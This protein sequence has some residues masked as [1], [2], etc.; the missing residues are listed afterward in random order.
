MYGRGDGVK[1]DHGK[2]R[3]WFA[4]G[5]AAGS[6]LAMFNLG[7]CYYNGWGVAADQ[8]LAIQWLEKSDRAGNRAANE[9]IRDIMDPGRREREAQFAAN[10]QRA[11]HEA[12][13]AEKRRQDFERRA[14]VRR[15]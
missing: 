11:K 10:R 3:Q 14:A 8:S 2:A 4:R 9:A 13:E 15:P 12:D 5:A 7:L 6:S 1:Q